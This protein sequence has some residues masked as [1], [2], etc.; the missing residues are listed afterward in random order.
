[1]LILLQSDGQ[2]LDDTQEIYVIIFLITILCY[3]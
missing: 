2:C 3:I 1:M